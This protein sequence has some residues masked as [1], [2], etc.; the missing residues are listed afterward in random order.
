MGQRAAGYL[1]EGGVTAAPRPR[2]PPHLAPAL[3]GSLQHPHPTT[4]P[5]SFRAQASPPGLSLAC[6]PLCLLRTLRAALDRVW[7]EAGL[8]GLDCAIPATG[9]AVPVCSP[10]LPHPPPMPTQLYVAKSSRSEGVEHRSLPRVG[11]ALPPPPCLPVPETQGPAAQ[12]AGW[13]PSL[14]L[15]FLTCRMGTG[16]LP[17]PGC[18]ETV[19]QDLPHPAPHRWPRCGTPWPLQRDGTQPDQC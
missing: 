6:W 13:A 1:E 14:N 2:L 19:R 12:L 7:P 10:A 5:P 3:T 16:I 17:P 4:H 11:A 15:S 18:A 8:L 9:K